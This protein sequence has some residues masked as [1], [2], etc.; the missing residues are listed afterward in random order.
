[1]LKKMKLHALSPGQW[2]RVRV[3]DYDCW[4]KPGEW[5]GL[6]AGKEV[7]TELPGRWLVPFSLRQLGSRHRLVRSHLRSLG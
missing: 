6:M 2:A 3:P 4:Q 1:M 5:S 7:G